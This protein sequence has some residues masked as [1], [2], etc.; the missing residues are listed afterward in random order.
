MFVVF[1]INTV[2][3]V[4]AVV[5][6]LRIDSQTFHKETDGLLGS[7]GVVV[8]IFFIPVITFINYHIHEFISRSER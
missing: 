7:L 4:I 2:L 1:C 3:L 8:L 6:L 5:I